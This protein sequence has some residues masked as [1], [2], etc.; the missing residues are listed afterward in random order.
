MPAQ[1]RSALKEKLDYSW[2]QTEGELLLVELFVVPVICF[3]FKQISQL[4]S[5]FSAVVTL[6]Q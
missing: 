1:V 4:F 6:D 3:Q 2:S 5:R